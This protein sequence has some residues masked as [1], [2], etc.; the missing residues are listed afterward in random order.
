MNDLSLVDIEDLINEIMKRTETCVI[1]YT[2]IVDIGDPVV[3]VN[4]SLP[5]GWVVG[6]GLC[7]IM[8]SSI[9]EQNWQNEE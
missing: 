2:R 6:V 5:A 8:K 4:W 1:A 9:I 3:R 7:D